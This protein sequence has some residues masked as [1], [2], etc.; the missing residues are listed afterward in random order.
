MNRTSQ[1][2]VVNSTTDEAELFPSFA[3]VARELY[4]NQVASAGERSILNFIMKAA[5]EGTVGYGFRY[6]KVPKDLPIEQQQ[7]FIRRILAISAVKG[8]LNKLQEVDLPEDALK[9]LE[10]AAEHLDQY[11]QAEDESGD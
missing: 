11:L 4:T 1:I 2:I 6:I 9:E 5:R 10:A 3:L 7:R 8:R